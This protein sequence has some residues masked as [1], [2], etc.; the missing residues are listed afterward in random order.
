MPRQK[1]GIDTDEITDSN[2]K[3]GSL[4]I[5]TDQCKA[6]LDMSVDPK[7]TVQKN[8]IEGTQNDSSRLELLMIQELQRDYPLIS[9]KDRR[10]P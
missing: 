8:N 1:R 4:A 7:S 5:R 2:Q 9:L 6:S 3:A 10:A